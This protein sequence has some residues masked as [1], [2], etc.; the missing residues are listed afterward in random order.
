MPIRR[1]RTSRKAVFA[2]EGI[3]VASVLDPGRVVPALTTLPTLLGP[4][5][6]FPLTRVRF[7]RFALRLTLMPYRLQVGRYVRDPTLFPGINGFV[8]TSA[9]TLLLA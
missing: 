9:R 7:R 2:G 3:Y 1:Q 8:P 4:V 6:T 5:Y